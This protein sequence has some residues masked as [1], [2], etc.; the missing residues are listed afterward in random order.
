MS[1]YSQG[2]LPVI[3]GVVD[4]RSG[5]KGKVGVVS[6]KPVETPLDRSCRW[7]GDFVKLTTRRDV[8]GQPRQRR[9]ETLN[10]TGII[11]TIRKLPILRLG[12]FED[13]F[14]FLELLQ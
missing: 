7:S 8:A 4:S 1:R 3:L 12:L 14:V 5:P 11:R 10:T 6:R 9:T 2:E 13:F